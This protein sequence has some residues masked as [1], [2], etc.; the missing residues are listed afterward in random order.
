[1]S[2]TADDQKRGLFLVFT[3]TLAYG[4]MPIFAKTTYEAGL[5]SVT[6]LAW[7]FVLAT[8]LFAL[9]PGRARKRLEWGDHARLWGIGS[10]FVGNAVLYFEGLTRLPASTTAVIVYTYPVIVTVLSGLLGFERF[11][12][13]A[14][15]SALLAF[16]GC[17]LTA[18]GV[19]GGGRTGVWLVL[20]SAFFYAVYLLLGSRLASHLPAEAA[21]SH[22]AQAAAVVCTPIAVLRDTVL[23][24]PTAAAWASVAAIATLSTVVA[25][26]TL[27]AG[28]A[29]IGPVRAAVLS[30]F[31]V[32]V[33]VCLSAVFLGERLGPRKL[34]GAALILGAVIFQNLT[35]LASVR[36]AARLRAGDSTL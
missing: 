3:S 23:V 25:L 6:L 17:A 18:G 22:T 20:A 7:R 33:T 14:V 10:V 13:R 31:E 30:S 21:A 1:M 12:L 24:P 2:G 36:R 5:A 15:L 9:I 26:R 11:T 27:L 35:M 19:E 28:M 29:R 34:G 4:A 8:V 32:V 16:C